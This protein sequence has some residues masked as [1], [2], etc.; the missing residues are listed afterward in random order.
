M[1]NLYRDIV[2]AFGTI[3][4]QEDPAIINETLKYYDERTLIVSQCW[5]VP[6]SSIFEGLIGSPFEDVPDSSSLLINGR[7]WGVWGNETSNYCYKAL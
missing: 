4:I 2:W 7:S 3:L 6:V 5:H 1:H